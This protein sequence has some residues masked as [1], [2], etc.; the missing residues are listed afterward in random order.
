MG[1]GFFRILISLLSVLLQQ[2]QMSP[3]L[4]IGIVGSESD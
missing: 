2:E 3:R 1:L 4:G